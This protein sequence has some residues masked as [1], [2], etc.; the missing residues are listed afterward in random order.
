MY[1]PGIIAREHQAL[2]FSGRKQ[3]VLATT[4]MSQSALKYAGTRPSPTNHSC[5]R[6]DCVG[7]QIE[8]VVP[9]RCGGLIAPYTQKSIVFSQNLA[10]HPKPQPRACIALGGEER[11]EQALPYCPVHSDSIVRNGDA[12]SL[13][14]GLRMFL[15][16]SAQLQLA[17]AFACVKRISNQIR[18]YL[19]QL[20]SKAVNELRVSIIPS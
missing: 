3:P 15:I 5:S 19:A 17:A 12:N 14:A 2:A 13:F 10:A 6:F 9:L 18:K 20:G 7:S 11:L 8:N 16:P 4:Y 1:R